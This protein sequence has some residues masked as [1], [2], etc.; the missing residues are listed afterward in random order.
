MTF[1]DP[2]ALWWL[3][4]LGGAIVLLYLL[5]MRRRDLRVPAT[6]LWPEKV[7]EVR[8]NSLFQRLRPSWLLFLQLLALLLVVSAF[9]R[10]QSLQRGLT[11]KVTV[12]VLDASAS[13]SATDVK[14]SR[15]EVAK[16]AAEDAIQ[17]ARAG[18][19]VALIEAG[20]TPRVIFPLSNDPARQLLALKPVSVTQAESNVGDALRLAAALVGSI[21]G[22]RIVLL[23]DGVFEPV[24]NFAPGKA[25]FVYQAVGEFDD[26]LAISALGASETQSGRQLYCGVK[27]HGRSALDGTL[28]IRADGRVLD[29][30]KIPPIPAGELWGR[31]I[32]APAGARVFE[33]S[34][35]ARDALKADNYAVSLSDPGAS[36]NVLLVTRGNPFLERALALDPRVTLDK[37]TQI[38]N[39]EAEGKYDLV[40]FDGIDE[41][42]VRARGVLTFGAAGP[43]SPV[44]S[45]GSAARPAF[46]SQEELPLLEGV[47]LR[48]TYVDRQEKVAIRAGSQSIA[49]SSGGP[50][51]VT[52]ERPGKRQIYVAFAP[53][54]SDFPL[55]IGFPI[56]IANA[57]DFLSGGEGADTLAIK[58]G[59]AFSVPW[60]KSAT[61]THEGNSVT[62]KPVGAAL[63]VREVVQIGRYDLTDGE[64][65]K[66]I[67]SALRSDRE[68][69]IAPVKSIPLGG[70]VVKAVSAPL[71]FADLWR[72]LI[73]LALVVLGAEWWLFARRS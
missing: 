21:D 12:I 9:A 30:V 71:R 43:T 31:T 23:S 42:P 48:S 63:V 3:A 65:R 66:T 7:E 57:L 39:D 1:V 36:L 67:Y 54:D 59:Q 10:P 53:L 41:Q 72:P 29:S 13:M 32:P 4:P 33:A 64:H 62:V 28:T 58:P 6:F 27:N 44:K 49:E 16:R 25:A 70:G 68:S 22:A 14:P 45:T 5:K 47:D 40:V 51:V 19:R 69:S 37:S 55:Q 60:T 2:A 52:A 20:P 15:F 56:F 8:A 34:I 50:L 38:P 18:D 35:D 24:A 11:G 73:L 46:R 61:L 17:S 26:N